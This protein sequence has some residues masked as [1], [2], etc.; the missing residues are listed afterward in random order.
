MSKDIDL[1][2][3]GSFF[4]QGHYIAC[5]GLVGWHL[6]F[7]QPVYPGGPWVLVCSQC[8]IGIDNI[9][10]PDM[11]DMIMIFREDMPVLCVACQQNILENYFRILMGDDKIFPALK[12][13]C[14]N[15]GVTL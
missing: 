10:M 2:V 4:V 7:G 8:D 3:D 12:P 1:D 11:L 6:K 13:P 14:S 5:E 15:R 9:T